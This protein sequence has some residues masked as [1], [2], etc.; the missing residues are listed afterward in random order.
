MNKLLVKTSAMYSLTL[1]S[2]IAAAQSEPLVLD[3][4]IVTA[5]KREQSL[6]NVPLS[7]AVETSASLEKKGIINLSTL[8]VQVPNLFIEDG[9]NTPTIAMRGLGSPGI[10][11]IESSVGLYID[12]ISLPRPRGLTQN[13]FFDLERIEVLRGPQGTL[14][15]RN[16]IVGAIN[17]LT[18]APTSELYGHASIE[19]GNYGSHVGEVVLSG[20]LSNNL[21]GRLS[22]YNMHSGNFIENK[23]GP[24][25]GG[26]D[27]EAYRVKMH[28]QA[29][30]NLSIQLKYEHSRNTVFGSMR[31]YIA[32]GPNIFAGVPNT[33]NPVIGALG[34]NFRIDTV[35]YIPGDGTLKFTDPRFMGFASHTRQS[36]AADIAAVDVEWSLPGDYV[37]RSYSGYMNFELDRINN[38]GAIALNNR[39][40][41]MTISSQELRLE[42][43]QIGALNFIAGL[44]ADRLKLTTG[45][46]LKDGSYAII[47]SASGTVLRS[48][49]GNAE[50][51]DSWSTYLE[52]GVDITDKLRLS[53]GA[54]YGKEDKKFT[55]AIGLELFSRGNPS[56]RFITDELGRPDPIFPSQQFQILK[57]DKDYLT[58][59]VRLQYQMTPDVM[60]YASA[61]T[62]F[63]SGGFNNAANT[64]ILANKTFNE[65]TSIA[66]EIGAKSDIYGGRGR[67]N[68]ALFRTDFDDLQVAKRTEQGTVITTNAAQAYT[69]GLELESI[70]RISDRWTIGGSYSF[71]DAKY[72]AFKNAPCGTLQQNN[73]PSVCLNGQDLSGKPLQHAPRHSGSIYIEYGKKLIGGW[74]LDG[75]LGWSFRDRVTTEISNEFVTD[76]LRLVDARIQVAQP[77][78]GWIIAIKGNNL[79]DERALIDRT[80]SS[81]LAGVQRG[82]INMPRTY[83]LHIKKTL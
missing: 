73:N 36:S 27:A 11:S 65:E 83:A 34:E 24:D 80:A 74:E 1:A 23:V 78:L 66:L 31:Q 26:R 72:D 64:L 51:V 4:I 58:S 75:Y 70:W 40:D 56:G 9:G 46:L 18:A 50:R 28:W 77:E 43:P 44:Y 59:S 32:P 81:T 68:M 39:G 62:G 2:A 16:T 38:D 29:L 30:N 8:S 49:G 55:N 79:T 5:Q 12:N 14:W 37:L 67:L 48:W 82:T 52:T 35:Q 25:S 53:V 57:K 47:Q 33:V 22:V 7:V 20:P 71:L 41:K 54:R 6:Q 69:Q 61:A 17:I 3:E 10:E 45:T 42:S 13:P 19:T 60:L 76:I 21:T 15:G 63:K